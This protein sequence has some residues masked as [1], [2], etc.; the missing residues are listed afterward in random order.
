MLLF[1]VRQTI[2]PE[3]TKPIPSINY[4]DIFYLFKTY[5]VTKVTIVMQLLATAGPRVIGV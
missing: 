3:I 5:S 4:E 1:A 2:I